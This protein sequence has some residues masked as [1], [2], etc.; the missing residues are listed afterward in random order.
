MLWYLW[1]GRWSERSGNEAETKRTVG[2]PNS[3]GGSIGINPESGYKYIFLLPRVICNL[4][5][6]SFFFYR[7]SCSFHLFRIV[8]QFKVF[9]PAKIK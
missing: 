4:G 3:F 7:F 6:Y 9:K 8:V 2:E 5:H 1:N